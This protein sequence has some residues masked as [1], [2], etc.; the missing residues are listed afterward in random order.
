[1]NF[2]RLEVVQIREENVS[3]HDSVSSLV[4]RLVDDWL[5]FHDCMRVLE[6]EL[7]C[8]MKDVEDIDIRGKLQQEYLKMMDRATVAVRK[9][10]LSDAE[11]YWFV[12]R[13]LILGS[14]A[15]GYDLDRVSGDYPSE[16]EEVDLD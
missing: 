2:S 10:S 1:M 8:A 9:G 15:V 12:A 14:R 16:S 5:T 7:D 13:G 3:K 6:E 4:V 11:K